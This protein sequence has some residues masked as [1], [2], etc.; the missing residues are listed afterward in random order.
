MWVYFLHSK[1]K[2]F[3]KFKIWLKLVENESGK[4]LKKLCT[5]RGGEFTSNEFNA[6]CKERG[7]KRDLTVAHTPQQNGVVERKNRTVVE[8]VRSML[9][10]RGLPNTF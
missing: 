5:D 9:K 2:A 10:G 3:E 1:A 6:Y 8:M 7:I 4:K